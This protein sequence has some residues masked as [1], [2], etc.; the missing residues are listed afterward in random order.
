MERQRLAFDELIDQRLSQV[1][2]LKN[3]I[4]IF[5]FYFKGFSNDCRNSD[6]YS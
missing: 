6:T 5:Y 1:E 4:L 3:L 2:F